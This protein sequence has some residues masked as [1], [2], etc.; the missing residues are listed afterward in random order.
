MIS[1]LLKKV[2]G[3]VAL[4]VVLAYG[5]VS[6]KAVLGPRESTVTV[7]PRSRQPFQ[8][9]LFRGG[10]LAVLAVVEDG[11][12]VLDLYVYDAAGN[13]VYGDEDGYRECFVMFTPR[14]S[15][16]YYVEVVNRGRLPNTFGLATN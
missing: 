16:Y 15:G 6:A 13:L 3:V 2:T 7:A 8:P 5:N 11:S 4:Q 12:T 1:H 14:R 9:I 10:E